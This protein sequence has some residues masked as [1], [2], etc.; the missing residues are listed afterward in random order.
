MKK[1]FFSWLATFGRNWKF[2][3]FLQFI[4]S[5]SRTD[6]IMS[7]F[8]FHFLVHI[9]HRPSFLEGS[10]VKKKIVHFFRSAVWQTS[11]LCSASWYPYSLVISKEEIFVLGTPESQKS[12]KSSP[13]SFL[14]FYI[15]FQSWR[16]D[17]TFKNSPWEIF[18]I[19]CS[20]PTNPSL[21]LSDTSDMDEQLNSGLQIYSCNI[22]QTLL[23]ESFFPFTLFIDDRNHCIIKDLMRNLQTIKNVS[24]ASKITIIS[25]PLDV[26]ELFHTE[27][28][29]WNK[30][31]LEC[32][33]MR[34]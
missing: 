5:W 1:L 14:C 24:V 22:L 34:L 16:S 4:E 23:N 2:L 17:L 9:L 18:S 30:T 3:Q 25:G 27:W 20:G 13:Y 32:L 11:S 31:I 19:Y 6:F 29:I 10:A 33:I 28:F 26:T 21:E 12:A 8:G 7:I 15:L